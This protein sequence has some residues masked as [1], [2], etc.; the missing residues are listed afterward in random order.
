MDNMKK[1]LL[2]L[3][4]IIA[5]QA[6]MHAQGFP[7]VSNDGSTKWYLIQFMNGGKAFTAS[8]SGSEIAVAAATGADE[9]LSKITGNVSIPGMF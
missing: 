8:A 7:E 1:Y 5:G 2:L 4:C 6:T 9:Q 3:L